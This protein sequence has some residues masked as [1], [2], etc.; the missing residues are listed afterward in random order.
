MV[1]R[2]AQGDPW[3]I[4]RLHD[5]IEGAAGTA[6]PGLMEQKAVVLEHYDAML[7]HYGAHHGAR[8]ARKHICW[9][10]RSLP[11]AAAFRAEVNRI[12]APVDVARTIADFYD[13]S[14]ERAAA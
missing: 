13:A 4:K 6:E 14:A 2:A 10:S 12:D 3:I 11:G 8:I 9:Y 7:R 5:F 1:G